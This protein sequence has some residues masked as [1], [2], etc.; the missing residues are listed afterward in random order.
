MSIIV[1]MIPEALQK[2]RAPS[3][4][5][6]VANGSQPSSMRA[7]ATMLYLRIARARERSFRRHDESSRLLTTRRQRPLAEQGAMFGPPKG[8]RLCQSF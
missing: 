5:R 7:T 4:I 1:M 3:P 8:I 2:V 6:F